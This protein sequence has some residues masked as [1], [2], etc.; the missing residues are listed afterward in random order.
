MIVNNFIG[1]ERRLK[2]VGSHSGSWQY[3]SRSGREERSPNVNNYQNRY[4][5]QYTIW[6]LTKTIYTGLC[7]SSRTI[8]A[9]QYL[10]L[11]VHSDF[12]VWHAVACYRGCESFCLYQGF[13]TA[14][15]DWGLLCPCTIKGCGTI[16][17]N[18]GKICVS[19]VQFE[20]TALYNSENI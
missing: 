3:M 13:S 12:A 2:F 10:G 1:N 18:K 16:G 7:W 17:R 15:Y 19:L 11:E 20:I 9:I 4:K 14:F 8:F 5:N 6:K